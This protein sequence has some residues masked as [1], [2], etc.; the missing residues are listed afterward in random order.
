MASVSP[1]HFLLNREPNIWNL[2]LVYVKSHAL[3]WH[4][5]MTELEYSAKLLL[6]PSKLGGIQKEVPGKEATVNEAV[7][8]YH[9]ALKVS[10]PWLLGGL[11][12]WP[13]TSCF[14]SISLDQTLVW[15][16]ENYEFMRRKVSYKFKENSCC[17]SMRL[18]S[19]VGLCPPSV[20]FP[21]SV[22]DNEQQYFWAAFAF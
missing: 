20:H 3:L 12:A 18:V 13:R 2:V 8:L 17:P 5:S 1:P 16:C 19:T 15:P 6:P 9:L 4:V 21:I 22:S 11:V 10:P 14:V 7:E